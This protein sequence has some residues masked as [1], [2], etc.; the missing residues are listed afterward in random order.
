MQWSQIKTLFILCFLVLDIYLLVQFIDKQDRAAQEQYPGGEDLTLQEELEREDITLEDIDVGVEKDSSIS[1]LPMD[2]TD[3]QVGEI[4]SLENQEAVL[5]TEDLIVG[6]MDEPVPIAEDAGGEEISNTISNFIYQFDSYQ[7]W[8]W[9]KD[10][11]VLL[12]FQEKENQPIY[13]NQSALLLVYLNKDNE[14]EYY[15]QSMLGVPESKND[16]GK[17]MLIQP[18][19]AIGTLYNNNELVSKDTVDVD[20]GYHTW[21]SSLENGKQ[22]FAPTY[23]VSVNDERDYF[24]N[25]IEG[26]VFSNSDE[27]FTRDMVRE[28]LGD[29]QLI[30]QDVDW[31]EDLINK[32]RTLTQKETETETNRSE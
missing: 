22:V 21:I 11:N 15:T 25:A 13:Y 19:Q 27:S 8:K 9:D 26:Q 1:V 20:Y 12:F 29:I 18:I 7:F 2:Y 14:M 3:K 31:K 28:N 30:P 10:L 4:E 5:N 16:R 17:R 23:K 32:L 6:H 24:V